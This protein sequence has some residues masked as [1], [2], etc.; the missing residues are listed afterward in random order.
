MRSN[1][2]VTKRLL[3]QHILMSLEKHFAED[4]LEVAYTLWP[5]FVQTLS[6]WEYNRCFTREGSNVDLKRNLDVDLISPMPRLT[7]VTSSTTR[8][9]LVV[10]RDNEFP[11]FLLSW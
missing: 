5:Q 11:M 1:R 8:Y 9:L 7:K 4:S 2:P 10:D 3:W 6:W